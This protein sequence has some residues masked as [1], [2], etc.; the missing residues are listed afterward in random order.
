[1][2][3]VFGSV[4]LSGES[5][6]LRSRSSPA[7][8]PSHAWKMSSVQLAPAELAGLVLESCLTGIALVM[9]FA[10]IY[11]LAYKRGISARVS[12]RPFNR[13]LF[14]VMVILLVCVVSVRIKLGLPTVN[15]QLTKACSRF[16]ALDH[17]YCEG[18]RRVHLSRSD[19]RSKLYFWRS[20]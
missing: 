3:V 6:S 16:T 8:G 15:V 1:M 7:P 17:K 2:L 10:A 13:L 12:N 14:T 11:V 5:F 9:F 4:T 19:S 20:V 18:F